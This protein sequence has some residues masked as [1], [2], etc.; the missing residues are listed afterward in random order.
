MDDLD[1]AKEIYR[2][3]GIIIFF[4]NYVFFR[5]FNIIFE[6]DIFIEVNIVEIVSNLNID[7]IKFSFTKKV[8][9]FED[10]FVENIFSSFIGDI[11]EWDDYIGDELVGKVNDEEF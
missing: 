11:F 9:K 4:I 1:I 5:I 6:D 3:K 7:F 8:L 10:F 2:L